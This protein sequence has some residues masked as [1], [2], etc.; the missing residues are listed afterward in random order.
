MTILDLDT[1]ITDETSAEELAAIKYRGPYYSDFDSDSIET[2]IPK[3]QQF[4][5]KLEALG[6]PMGQCS[7]F[8]SGGKGFHL[9]IPQ[10]V[11][12]EKPAQAGYQFLPHIYREV[13]DDLYV[14]TLD[15]RVYTARRGRM[16]RIEN[17]R[18][19]N[20]R[21]KVPIT[22][23]EA[24]AM[25]PEMYVTL[26]STPRILPA[27][28]PPT[29][30]ANLA[31]KFVQAKEKVS[32]AMERRKKNKGDA[33]LITKFKGEFPQSLA[34]VL[35]GSAVNEGVGFQKLALQ[36]AIVA[37]RL[38]KTEEQLLQS[39]EGLIQNHKSDGNR[40]NTPSKRREEL[41]RMYAYMHD[42]PCYEMTV[43]G[44]KS[45]MPPG[46]P[47]PDLDDGLDT[48]PNLSADGEPLDD[49]FITLG[50]RV[51]RAGIF[52]K[53]DDGT[54]KVSAA[55]W[56]NPRE[57]I[58]L[59]NGSSY[60]FIVDAYR[61]GHPMGER[62][63][64][65]E[66]FG[67][68][69]KMLAF[70]HELGCNINAT[71]AQVGG[72][73]DTTRTLAERSGKSIIALERE[74]VDVIRLPGAKT[75][76]D[77]A[78]VYVSRD[79]VIHGPREDRLDGLNFT[80]HGRRDPKG[81][82]KTDIH[83][84][85]PL[86]GTDEERDYLDR[87]LRLNKRVHVGKLLGFI[88][89]SWVSHIIRKGTSNFPLVQAYGEPQSG[90]STL[91]DLLLQ[92]HFNQVKP[93]HAS[94]TSISNFF[95]EARVSASASIPL[96]LDEF[97]PKDMQKYKVDNVT[98]ILRNNWDEQMIGKGRV[99]K[100]TNRLET[101]TYPN[102][103]PLI[104]MC[105]H[106]ISDQAIV[107]RSILVPM[108]PGDRADVPEEEVGYCQRNKH[109]LSRWGRLCL[110]GAVDIRME[111]L[112]DLL[113][114]SKAEIGDEVKRLMKGGETSSKYPSRQIHG[115]GVVLTGLEFGRAILADKFGDHFD[116]IFEEFKTAIMADVGSIIGSVKSDQLSVLDTIA[117][118]SH[119]EE[120]EYKLRLGKEYGGHTDPKTKRLYVDIQL[121]Q[122]FDRYLL[123]CKRIGHTPIYDKFEPFRKAMENHSTCVSKNP[124]SPIRHRMTEFIS[125]FDLEM[126]AKE[127][128]TGF[129]D[130]FDDEKATVEQS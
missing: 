49:F 18:R 130:L 52:A 28:T 129:K 46:T 3:F 5:G 12:I 57:L 14:D 76:K 29:Y 43:G 84:C 110:D 8:A 42:N 47:T 93:L 2:V 1:A 62:R 9:T 58:S 19:K 66:Y 54:V 48:G 126:L 50:M 83:E 82:F 96:I 97:K 107:E 128:V 27:P 102:G 113:D 90:K 124:M 65:K 105:E 75:G 127:K 35:D 4:I 111:A 89:A 17:V 98:A 7:L 72:L 33:K 10:Q 20:D 23:A 38:G 81:E 87:V 59:E 125:R 77:F 40:Y 92:L 44:M 39:A 100:V 34:A 74:G 109:L 79:G 55:G 114:T 6:V 70:T 80:L 106:Y 64:H 78:V 94:C 112:L 115:L 108:R 120:D 123:Y 86:T 16:F 15:M 25:T 36:L 37:H 116:G 13:A 53:K 117:Q 30:C 69:A 95:M 101:E 68:R 88:L 31:L 63:L 99:N 26:T 11:F 41:R 45:M 119:A 21:Y 22:L 71:D 85:D 122:A 104:F 121:T 24:K 32:K 73:L 118:L 56:D 61:D 67:S 103:A 91:I 51:S 60:G